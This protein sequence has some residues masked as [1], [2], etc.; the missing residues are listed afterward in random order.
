[1]PPPLAALR[2][3]HPAGAEFGP[4]RLLGYDRYKL[5]HSYDPD[6]PLHPGDALHLVLYWQAQERPQVDWK[7][8][9]KMTS[10]ANPAAPAA[11]GVFPVAG[12]DYP[13]TQWEPGEVV[14]AQF[15]LFLPRDAVR[16]GYQV[17]VYLVDEAGSPVTEAFSLAPI[18]VE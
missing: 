18:L 6:T 13:T 15:D 1:M 4:L 14:R 16:E 2:F 12:L 3:R 11:E 9:L 5:G 10:I 8:A 7:L 17:S